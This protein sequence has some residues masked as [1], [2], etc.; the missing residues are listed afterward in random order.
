METLA[1]CGHSA[2]RGDA[3][4]GISTLNST[5]KRGT[6]MWY[7]HDATKSFGGFRVY[8]W[9]MYIGSRATLDE[10]L[11]LKREYE[12]SSNEPYKVL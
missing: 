6:A 3:I 12:A 4:P 8:Y 2:K 7:I 5:P 9:K 1:R 11:S 10:A